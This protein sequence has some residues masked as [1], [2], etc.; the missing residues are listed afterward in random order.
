MFFLIQFY[1]L[2]IELPCYVWFSLSFFPDHHFP[3][4]VACP[5]KVV[6]NLAMWCVSSLLSWDCLS[7]AVQ[8][9]GLSSS[10][11]WWSGGSGC[12][13]TTSG[14]GAFLAPSIYPSMSEYAFITSLKIL[15]CVWK[16]Q[17][18]YANFLFFFLFH[19][20]F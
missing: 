14:S 9:S 20:F 17:V 2:F 6:T 3:L 19:V 10:S 11:W 15:F 4:K 18:C 8:S 5:V 13:F 1:S 7:G 12:T 16:C